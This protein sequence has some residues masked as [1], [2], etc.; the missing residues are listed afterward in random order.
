MKRTDKVYQLIVSGDS[1]MQDILRLG[2]HRT[3]AQGAVNKLIADGLVFKRVENNTLVYSIF[4]SEKAEVPRKK[5]RKLVLPD[6]P[7]I[8]L[9]WGGYTDLVPDPTIGRI[10]EGAL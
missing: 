10:I 4:P 6:L 8:M 7:P 5:E 9:Q 3:T 2:L 1:T